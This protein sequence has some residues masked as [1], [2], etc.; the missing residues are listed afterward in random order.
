MDEYANIGLGGYFGN[1]HGHNRYSYQPSLHFIGVSGARRFWWRYI[2]AGNDRK[3]V[4]TNNLSISVVL[5]GSDPF[6]NITVT[7][8]GSSE[9]TVT[10]TTDGTFNITGTIS[11]N[12]GSG[13]PFALYSVN[14]GS[15]SVVTTDYSGT[16]SARAF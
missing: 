4:F 3:F 2:R 9:Q 1:A 7:S 8:G 6:N 13:Q 15:G 16:L 14:N 11:G 5:T 12:N 10:N